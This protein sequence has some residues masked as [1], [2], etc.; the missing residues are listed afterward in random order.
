MGSVY[1][2][3][4]SYSLLCRDENV[5][6]FLD[7]A[8]GVHGR[9]H[10]RLTRLGTFQIRSA[11]LNDNE[12]IIFGIFESIV[13]LH[14]CIYL[15]QKSVS[16]RYRSAACEPEFFAGNQ[17]D[18]SLITLNLCPTLTQSDQVSWSK[19]TSKFVKALF[20]VALSQMI[21]SGTPATHRSFLQQALKGPV[22][23][24]CQNSPKYFLAA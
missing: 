16:A 4:Q 1:V 8:K 10:Q 13:Y 9:S 24:L 17:S 12:L 2:Y 19:E 14:I 20:L 6:L 23:D 3:E 18:H 7:L 15:A 22:P 5:C 21:D 11:E